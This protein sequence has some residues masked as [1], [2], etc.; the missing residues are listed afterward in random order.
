ML[1]I[2]VE[3]ALEEKIAYLTKRLRTT[4]VAFVNEAIRAY[5]EDMEEY[6]AA[7]DAEADVKK[8]H[9]GGQKAP[10]C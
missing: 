3:P 5:V 9:A 4:P 1:S 8:A 2:P 6:F 10:I 7:R